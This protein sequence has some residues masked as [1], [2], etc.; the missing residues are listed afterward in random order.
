MTGR[1]SRVV[2]IAAFA[3]SA[4]C[5]TLSGRTAPA[6]S[7]DWPPT[8][9]LAQA[10]AT[11]GEFDVADSLLTAFATRYAGSQEALE[12][13]Y[14]RALFK[15]DPSNKSGSVTTAIASLDGYLAAGRRRAHLTEAMTLRRAA[16]QIAEL[17]KLAASAMSQAHDARVS[18]ATA[19]AAA[20][21]AK[22]AAKA[23][24]PEQA[25]SPDA[26]AEIKRLK[27]ELAKANAELDRIK[28][29]LAQPPPHS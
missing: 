25:P 15:L 13:A 7:D 17:D 24:P 12:T 5:A 14:W 2:G 20:A 1:L 26:Q 6:A 18:A 8:I 3:L 19:N 22:D 9:A 29:R 11:R 4:G 27:E 21:D 23:A 10:H 16:A 28:K